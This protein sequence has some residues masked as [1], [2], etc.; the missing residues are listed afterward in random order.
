MA[1]IKSNPYSTN[2]IKKWNAIQNLMCHVLPRSTYLGD[3]AKELESLLNF[4]HETLEIYC[5][6]NC[7][8]CK[9]CKRPTIEFLSCSEKEFKEPCEPDDVVVDWDDYFDKLAKLPS[10][11]K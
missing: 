8:L 1:I 3:K 9:N 2:S 5:N 7:K 6:D 4:F 11:N 10:K